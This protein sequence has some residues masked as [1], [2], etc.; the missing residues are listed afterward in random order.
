MARIVGLS[1]TWQG[2]TVR[3]CAAAGAGDITYS[4]GIPVSA[5]PWSGRHYGSGSGRMVGG[6]PVSDVSI[7]TDKPGV[8]L[9]I[10]GLP[11]EVRFLALAQIGDATSVCP[12]PSNSDRYKLLTLLVP[13]GIASV[14]LLL[15]IQQ[16]QR[17]DFV[18]RPEL[19]V[20]TDNDR[21][22]P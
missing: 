20:E 1:N 7:G 12:E 5:A 4:N 11:R 3:V 17:L 13:E 9:E 2:V 22:E 10:A 16:P 14:D 21:Y 18:V 19:P 8:M 15:V 6:L